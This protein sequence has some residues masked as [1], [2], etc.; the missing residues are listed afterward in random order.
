MCMN[1]AVECSP[2]EDSE[3]PILRRDERQG[4]ALILYELHRRQMPSTTQLRRMDHHG[5]RAF[6]R[7]SDRY[8]VD[9]G[10]AVATRDLG[11]EGNQLVLIRD[12]RCTI[13]C[14]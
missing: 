14:R 12:H 8:L 9:P 3:T 5:H 13:G 7:F 4:V 2:R 11:A 10:V 1:H 6:Y